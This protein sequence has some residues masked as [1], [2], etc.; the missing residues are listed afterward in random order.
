MKYVHESAPVFSMMFGA[1]MASY[2][3]L[4][5]I[6]KKVKPS[7]IVYD[8]LF[9]TPVGQDQGMNSISINGNHFIDSSNIFRHSL[10]ELL[11]LCY[12]FCRSQRNAAASERPADRMDSRK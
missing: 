2:D 11:F 7:I 4:T 6:V 3:D 12:Q 10:G 8:Q 1:L 9:A 5:A